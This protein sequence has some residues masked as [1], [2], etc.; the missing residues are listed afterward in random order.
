[1]QVFAVVVSS[2]PLPSYKVWRAQRG[3]SPWKTAETPPGV[4][5][6]DNGE[7]IDA[8]TFEDPTGQRGKGRE[9]AGKKPVADLT[10]W[11]RQAPDVE[12]V[13]AVGFAVLPKRKP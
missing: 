2:R 11:L 5:W 1:L 8:L 12:A 13:A 7:E 4:V 3:K 10:D 6:R 9:V